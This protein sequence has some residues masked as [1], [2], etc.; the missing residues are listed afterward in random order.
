MGRRSA[1]SSITIQSVGAVGR[2]SSCWRSMRSATRRSISSVRRAAVAEQDDGP[3][4]VG[5]LQQTGDELHLVAADDR[6]RRL[7]PEVGLQP[8][9]Q[10]VAVAVPPVRARWPAR[11]SRMQDLA[12]VLVDDAVQGEQV[13][14]V[15]LLEADPARAPCG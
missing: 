1:A 10:H 15:A 11:A 8:G 3:R 5:G 12:L 9:R 6:R 14:D 7:Q 4:V 13:G 2:F